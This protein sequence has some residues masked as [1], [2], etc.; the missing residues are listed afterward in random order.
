MSLRVPFPDVPRDVWRIHHADVGEAWA[1]RRVDTTLPR[2]LCSLLGSLFLIQQRTVR[3]FWWKGA[4]RFQ[5]VNPKCINLPVWLPLCLLTCLPACPTIH[6]LMSFSES[7]TSFSR[8]KIKWG[9]LGNEEDLQLQ[10]LHRSLCQ[11][12]LSVSGAVGHYGSL[13]QEERKSRRPQSSHSFR[14]GELNP[15]FTHN[16][17]CLTF[18]WSLSSKSVLKQNCIKSC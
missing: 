16:C 8:H 11:R 9:R 4:A 18:T 6:V 7:S 10:H 13:L 1:G 15:V 2:A 3:M 12:L 5:K 14:M 17:V